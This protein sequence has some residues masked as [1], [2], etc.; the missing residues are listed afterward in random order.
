MKRRVKMVAAFVL[1]VIVVGLVAGG[2]VLQNSR[3]VS[4]TVTIAASP[5]AI[6]GLV[7]DLTGWARWSPLVPEGDGMGIEYAAQTAGEGATIR[8]TG[9]AGTGSLELTHCAPGVAVSYR[10]TM[11]LGGMSAVGK[12]ELKHGPPGTVVSWQDE[13]LVGS[14]P[15]WKWLAFAMDGL[16]EKNVNRGLAA[17]K[18][19]S[20]KRG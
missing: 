2:M 20:E 5:D 17:L 10:T 11:S 12:I 9:R 15:A 4:G 6:Y 14:N 7:S 13:L 19:L 8:W 16:R 3:V 18:R 1:V